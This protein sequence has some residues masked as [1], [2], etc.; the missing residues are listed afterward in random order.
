MN[1]KIKKV[2]LID[3]DDNT[4]VYNEFII[5]DT[6]MVDEIIIFQEAEK[7]LAYLT[8]KDMNGDYPNPEIILLDINMPVMNG[9]EFIEAYEKLD[10]SQQAQSIILMLSSSMNPDDRTK[11]ENIDAVSGFIN[12]PISDIKFIE[13]VSKFF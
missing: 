1:K 12:K 6:N 9:W 3:D 2:V 11:A 10:K 8:T 5:A 7:A 13:I 4:N